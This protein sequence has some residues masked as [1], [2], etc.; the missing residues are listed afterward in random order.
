[1]HKL[2]GYYECNVN[3]KVNSTKCLYL[4]TWGALRLATANMKALE[5]KI[6]THNRNR[7]QD[8]IKLGLK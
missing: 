4:K 2:I 7:L 6:I 3:R 8:I 5:H 1:M